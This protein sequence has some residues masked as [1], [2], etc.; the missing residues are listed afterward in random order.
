MKF[1]YILFAGL[2]VLTYAFGVDESAEAGG[3]ENCFNKCSNTFN[4]QQYTV[5][6]E[7]DDTYE[8]SACRVGC[9][10]C[11]RQISINDTNHGAC[12]DVCKDT[13]WLLNVDINNNS[14]PIVKGI[15]EPDKSCMFGCVIGLCQFVCTSG[16]VDTTVTP[17]NQNLWWNGN[18]D[19][20]CSIK[21]GA[22]RPGGYYSQNSAYTYYNNPSGAGGVSECCSNGYSLCNY[23]GPTTTQNYQ[24]VLQMAIKGCGDVPGTG[25][26]VKSICAFVKNPS[27]CGSPL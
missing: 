18:P 26:T 1:S 2:S 8:Y 10:V 24:N 11:A 23:V 4:N 9:N 5:N 25:K 20:G 12:F 21:T 17:E 15:V 22:I 6:A 16:T 3:V 27:N 7:G 19:D 14:F 13:N